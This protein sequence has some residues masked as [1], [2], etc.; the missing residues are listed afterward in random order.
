MPRASVAFLLGGNAGATGKIHAPVAFQDTRTLA[1]G[2][3]R[4]DEC[5]PVC[6]VHS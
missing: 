1:L 6:C 2:L 4:V 5:L 3:A